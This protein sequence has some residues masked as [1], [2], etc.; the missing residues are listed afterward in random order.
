[1][2]LFNRVLVQSFDEQSCNPQKVMGLC[3]IKGVVLTKAYLIHCSA[4]PTPTKIRDTKKASLKHDEENK[5][6]RHIVQG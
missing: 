4:L 6:T 5:E 2:G 1:M 3:K